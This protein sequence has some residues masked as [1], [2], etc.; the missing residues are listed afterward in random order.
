MLMVNFR[1]E[2]DTGYNSTK[3][4]HYFNISLYGIPVRANQPGTINYYY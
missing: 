3:I 2:N 4:H 1:Y